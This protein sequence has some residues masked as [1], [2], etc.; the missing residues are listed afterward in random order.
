MNKVNKKF[1]IF[2]PIVILVLFFVAPPADAQTATFF[3]DSEFDSLGRSSLSATQLVEGNSGMFYVENSYYNSLSS[4]QRAN[5]TNVVQDISNVFD[6]QIYSSLVSVFGSPRLPDLSGNSKITIL[7]HTMQQSVGGYFQSGDQFPRSQVSNSNERNILYLNLK[8]IEQY[9]TKEFLA[10]E[11]QHL[12]NYNQK[13]ILK[14]VREE[15]WLNELMSE[16]AVFI[17]GLNEGALSGTNLNERMRTFLDSPNTSVTNWNGTNQDY[18]TARIFAR[19][20]LDQYGTAL[21]ANIMQTN[22]TGIAAVNHALTS[23]SSPRNFN[24]VFRDWTITNVLNNCAVSFTYCYTHKHFTH[25][26]F[27]ITFGSGTSIGTSSTTNGTMQAYSARWIQ[28]TRD[29]N[30][31]RPQDHVLEI[32]FLFSSN[33]ASSVPYIVYVEGQLPRVF[34]APIISVQ[35]RAYAEDFGF[36][37]GEVVVVPSNQINSTISFQYSVELLDSVPEGAQSAQ[38]QLPEGAMVR[39]IGLPQVYIIKNGYKRWIQSPEIIDMYGHLRWE[40]IVEVP[41][42]TL[43]DYATS[44]VIRFAL[45]PRVYR[46]SSD[47]TKIWIMTEEEF[48]ALGYKFDMV[49]EVNER[50]FNF[51]D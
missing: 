4:S 14:G 24:D 22:L 9:H 19:Y 47:N 51:Y 41:V 33:I 12:I 39:E 28:Y 50:E 3:V 44:N 21:F 16:A 1:I 37:V 43:N 25:D 10:H 46:V 49:Y 29:I 35:S 11:L 20:M 5:L 48:L 42:G 17:A 15:L 27:L 31:T 18:A 6:A 32:E 2:A 40:D 23:L 34:F 26:N 45:D 36:T 8:Q 30:N 13:N 7:F 38:V